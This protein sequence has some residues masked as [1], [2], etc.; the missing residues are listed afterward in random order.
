MNGGM[1]NDTF[2]VDNAADVVM[3]A[4]LAGHRHGAVDGQLHARRNVENLTL[5]RRRASN[6][7]TFDDLAT[8]RRSPMA[9]TAGS[10]RAPARDQ[11]V[12]NP[13]GG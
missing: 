4:P 2:S 1:G 8:R 3:E 10:R 13:G 12:I 7:Q 11:E 9:I 6:T 5:P